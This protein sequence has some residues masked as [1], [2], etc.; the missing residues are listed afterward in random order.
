MSVGGGD[1]CV[2][3][4]EDVLCDASLR[5]TASSDGPSMWAGFRQLKDTVS[6]LPFKSS[7]K[8]FSLDNTREGPW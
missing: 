6:S 8:Y 1:S 7:L 5:E 4:E 3:E 2:E